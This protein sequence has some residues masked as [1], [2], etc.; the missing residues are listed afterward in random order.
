MLVR[1]LKS[2]TPKTFINT[3]HIK[4]FSCYYDYEVVGKNWEPKEPGEG[5]FNPK[6]LEDIKKPDYF[7][8]GHFHDWQIIN[9][10]INAEGKK[11]TPEEFIGEERLSN[12]KKELRKNRYNQQ[13]DY[14]RFLTDGSAY[15]W[16]GFKIV[17]EFTSTY[18]GASIEGTGDA[19]EDSMV[20][21]FCNIED[22]IEAA[23]RLIKIIGYEGI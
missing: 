19:V 2:F 8:K 21:R 22:C 4:S 9:Y 23:E 17:I 6:Y 10:Y 11:L 20:I 16:E 3:Q 12:Y 5:I 13:I 1:F 15:Y 14:S 7:I 18:P